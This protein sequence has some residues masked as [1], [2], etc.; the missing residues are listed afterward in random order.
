MPRI[1]TSAAAQVLPLESAGVLDLIDDDTEVMPGVKLRRSGGHTQHHQIIMLSSRG[2]TAVFT[3]D[4]FP[5]SAHVPDAWLMGYDL[6]PM[7]TLA[8]K[9]EFAREAIAREYLIFFEHDPSI[10]AGRIR[11]SGGKR[12]VERIL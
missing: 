12:Q 2:E 8:F 1:R 9:R 6:Y 3:A 5:T 10:A 11:E 4:M 7:D